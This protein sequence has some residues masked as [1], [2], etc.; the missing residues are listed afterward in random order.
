MENTYTKNSNKQK[1]RYNLWQNSAYMISAAWTM[2]MGSVIWFGIGIAAMLVATNVLGLLVAPR[3]LAAVE[4][5]VSLGELVR[6]ILLFSGGLLLAGPA[7]TYLQSNAVFGRMFMRAAMIS[8]ISEKMGTTSYPNLENQ[9]VRKMLERARTAT[10][11]NSASAEDIWRVLSELMENIA[12]LTIYIILL[13]SMTPW[14]PTLVLVTTIAGFFVTR[15]VN[16]WGYRHRDEFADSSRRMWYIEEKARDTTL[17]KDIRLF[18]M[19]DWLNDIRNAA[20]HLHQSL[21]ARRERVYIWANITEVVLNFARSGI[22]YVYLIGLVLYGDLAASQFLLYFMAI[23]GFTMW[24]NGILGNVSEL[25]VH[26]L[27]ITELRELL[28]YPEDFTFENGVPLPP[29]NKPYRIELR[30]V[31]FRY[32]GAESCTLKNVN[33]IINPGEKLAIVGLNGAGKTTLVKLVCGLYD[34]TE[35]EVLLNGE[36]IKKFNRHDYYKHFSAVFQEFSLFSTSILDNI[37]QQA[38]VDDNTEYRQDIK[39]TELPPVPQKALEAAARAGIAKKIESLPRGYRTPLSKAVYED[40]IHLSGGE[41]Q[42]LML[43]RALYKDAPIIILDE[44]TAAM[45]PIA[46]SDMYN[47]YH[48]L[49]GARTS[50]YISHRLASTRFCDRVIYIE[51]GEIT[52][53]GSHEDLIKTGGR[54][55]ELFELQSHYYKKDDEQTK[56]GA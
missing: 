7:G 22:A 42:R 17:A 51:N 44:P 25:H 33:L 9:K 6:I 39:D 38:L 19:R 5:G 40:G 3:I 30:N 23:G 55:A 54:Y 24:I 50:L 20:F 4:A 43:A 53:E 1:P 35:G 46:E 11:E 56:E 34:P 16:G 13:A 48:E 10:N 31:S 41:T 15:H 45:D 26:S 8:R 14:V 2:K 18:G 21:V 47:K 37:T 28:E 29:E 32:P 36:N 27:E 52:E 12:G 49:T